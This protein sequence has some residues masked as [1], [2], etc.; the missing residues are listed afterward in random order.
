MKVL[1]FRLHSVS[2]HLLLRLT[3]LVRICEFLYHVFELRRW[4]AFLVVRED[5]LVE[6]GKMALPL[7][8]EL[9]DSC[10]DVW[11]GAFLRLLWGLES[12]LVVSLCDG[13]L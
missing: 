9:F 6:I 3:S 1:E 5:Q 12:I 2:S 8:L 7:S 13:G 4:L 11:L 10:P